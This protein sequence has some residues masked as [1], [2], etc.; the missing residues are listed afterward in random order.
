[1]ALFGNF[2]YLFSTAFFALGM[3][4]MG[5]P[6][7][8]SKGNA[9]L[10][11]G[12]ITAVVSTLGFNASEGLDFN[13]NRLL[14]I[15]ALL[16]VGIVAGRKIS[17][18]FKITRMPE[19]VSLFNGFGGLCAALIGW[20]SLFQTNVELSQSSQVILLLSLFMGFSTFSGSMIAFFKLGG[21]L[22]KAWRGNNAYMWLTLLLSGVTFLSSLQ[23]NTFI[24]VKTSVLLLGLFSLSYGVFFANGVGGGDMPV[25][26]S[27]LNGLTGVLTTISGI[28]FENTIMILLG[29]FVGAT[30]VIL[31][32]QMCKAMNKSFVKIFFNTAKKA[33]HIQGEAEELDI[34]ETSSASIVADL[35]LAKKVAIV[36][37]YGLAIAQ[38]QKACYEL[39]NLLNAYDTDVKFVIHPVAGRMPGHMNVLLAEANIP[40]ADIL[41]L[42]KGNEYLAESDLCFVIG[43]NDVVNTSAETNENSPIYGMPIIQTY[44]AQKVVIIKR[45][46]SNGYADIQNPVFGLENSSMYFTDAKVGLES[47]VTELKER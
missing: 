22:K 35:T 21:K 4:Y 20:V 47:I 31:T 14:L 38:A 17:F 40:Y 9:L 25:L 44:L 5:N 39:K 6:K 2:G 3:V 8:A 45:S 26:I 1:M 16:I 30:G 24:D 29:V 19:L 10:I 41:D 12:M 28:Y 15:L 36:P 18:S 32:I 34:K 43:A 11:L 37:G 13:W 33:I 46:L 42:D 7:R 27:V 23:P